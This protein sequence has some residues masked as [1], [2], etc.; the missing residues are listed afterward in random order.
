V[1]RDKKRAQPYQGWA[2]L[3]HYDLVSMGPDGKLGTKDD[4]TLSQ[5]APNWWLGQMW[6]TEQGQRQ[7]AWG[8]LPH[9]RLREQVFFGMEFAGNQAKEMRKVAGG[10]PGEGRMRDMDRAGDFLQKNAQGKGE[11]R[12]GH[13]ATDSSGGPAPPRMREYFPET[14]LWQPAL[15]TDERGHATLPLDFADSITTWRLTASA[16]SRGGLLGGTS[17][18]LRVFQ[19]FF[20]DLDLP[21]ALTQNDEVAFPVAVYNYLKQPQTVKLDLQPEPWFELVDGK[22]LSRSL[23]LKPNEV[24]SVKFRIRAKR[25][26]HFP[27]TVKAQ[28][29]KMSDALKRGI[30]VLPDGKKIEQVVTDRLKGKVKQTITIPENALPDASKLLVK[31]YP[32]VMSQVLEGAEG[33]L[34]MPCGCFEQTSSSAYPNI[35]VADYIKKAR[36]A[37]PE[38]LL[39]VETYL[40]A[41]YQRLL[42]FERPGGG[43]DWWGSGPPLVWL[44]A[45]GLQEFNDMARVYPVDRGVITRTQAWLMKQREADGTWSNIGMTH[46][47]TI[48]SMGS[49]KLL[50]TSYVV[51]SLLDSGLKIPELKKS[52]EYI[53]DHIK[54]ESNAYILALAANALASWDAKDDST[55]EALV[56]VLA[57][58]H[59]Q[60]EAKPQWQAVCFPAKGQSLV[61]ARGESLTVETTA[62]AVLAMIKSGQFANDVNQALTYLIKSKDAGGTW[63]STSATILTLKALV[64]SAEAPRVKEPVTF[65][66]RVAGKKV[67]SG[68]VNDKNADVLQQF[69][70]KEHIR[71][72]ANEVVIDVK[73]ETSL[74]YQIVGRH[75]EPWQQEPSAEPVLDVAVSYDRTKLSTKDLLRAKATVRYRGKVPT[76]MVIVDLG[77]APGFTVDAG[78]F[79]EMV[80]AKKVQK[81]SVT[82]RQVILYL[83]DVKPGEVLSFEYTLK[84]KYPIKAK[85]PATVVYEYN[86]PANRAASR[87]VELVVDERK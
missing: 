52:V 49:P 24:T 72:G 18:P 64:A 68:E 36:L 26:G 62:L 2:Q 69:D 40:N 48:A 55:H 59:E 22:G 20:V 56:K 37:S 34:R 12:A 84:P 44:S 7:Q 6:W 43:F 4:V 32:G 35:L 71:T 10:K 41:G 15:I 30:D 5:N 11:G 47:E 81:Y 31:V 25:I 57:K 46:S 16:S 86:T 1:S 77:I 87:P 50:L 51:W 39:R 76:Y 65:D 21:L 67:A 8:A 14:L 53:R 80:G 38:M 85:T 23:D 3:D 9:R 75:Y 70:L 82:A 66:I 63:G 17:V 33:M 45:Y 83:G 74:M 54:D 78:D 42:T 58:L 27:L 61:Y 60:R 19:D 13:G 73:G 79:A 29:S 28:G